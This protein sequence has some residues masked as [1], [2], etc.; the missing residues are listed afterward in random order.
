MRWSIG[1][2]IGG[3]SLLVLAVLAV[4]GTV[5]YRSTTGLIESARQV[6]HT[7]KVLN[8][9]VGVLGA[10]RD[11][12]SNERAYIISGDDAYMGLYRGALAEV[13]RFTRELRTLTL[14]NPMQQQRLNALEPVIAARVATLQEVADLRRSAGF[15]PAAQAVSAGRGKAQMERI[16][17]L[18]GE[19]AAEE[20][21]LLAERAAAAAAVANRTFNV[22][23]WGTALAAL[24]KLG[25]AIYLSRS[26]AHPLGEI[27]IAAQAIAAGDLSRTV[28]ADNRRDEVGALS[29]SFALMTESLQKMTVASDQIA[30][31]DLTVVVHP[32]SSAD[33]LGKAFVTMTENLKRITG[34]I[35]QGVNSLSSSAQQ[36]VVTTTQVASGAAQ[37]ATAVSETTTTVEEVKQTAQLSA[38][39]AKYVS[40]SAQKAAQVALVGR[41]SV[42]D[43]IQG[44]QRIREQMESIAGSI[45][46]LSEQ[47][48]SI[49]EIM[50]T[51]SDLAEQSNLLAV[52][53]AIEAARAGEHGR[54]FAVVAQEVRSLAEQSKQATAQIRGI[55]GDIQKATSAAVMVTEQGSKAVDAGVRQSQQAGEA[56]Q[57]LAENVAE[58]AQAATQI[59]ASSQQQ[60]AGMDQI[61]SAMESIK[62]ASA[63]NVTSVRQ[64]EAAARNMEDLGQ[65]L[66]AVS[67]RFKV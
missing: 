64:T 16:L 38:Q 4:L 67:A 43:S 60:M 6:T 45:V 36:I 65:K 49:G 14:D 2:K 63:Q 31:G 37:T 18:A 23:L 55:L 46:R 26:I 50:L 3:S 59:A 28:R 34:D 10:L 30:A 61:A 66:K 24:G 56:V 1:S 8:A 39:K 22:I 40:D 52:N 21:R 29:R 32:R 51:V 62:L 19:V 47:G 27:S 25:V 35:Q 53:A 33:T 15:A 41:K 58:A 48:Q 17:S 57:K 54:G 12:E 7:H 20:N 42:E 13:D 11:A 5:S 44:M 9:V